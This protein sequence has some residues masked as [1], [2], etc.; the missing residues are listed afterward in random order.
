MYG[1]EAEQW[2]MEIPALVQYLDGHS[3]FSLDQTAWE[4][5]LLEFLRKTLGRSKEG[6][7]SQELSQELGRQMGSY[8][9]ASVEKAFLCK[10]LGTALAMGKD[11]AAVTGQ[12]RELL[13]MADY[14][15]GAETECLGS[16]LQLCARDQLDATLRALGDFE[17]EMAERE[18]SWHL[19]LCKGL[20]PWERDTVKSAL[21]LFY[22]RAAAQAPPQQLLPRL[23]DE[24]VPQILHHYSTSSQALG[25]NAR[26]M[27]TSSEC[28]PSVSPR[29]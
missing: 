5:K 29:A 25:L 18:D 24:I 8:A 21:L 9:S 19:S 11:V 1:D 17:E 20:A 26:Q 13:C 14:L 23:E 10:A 2:W 15:N 22:S 3:K 12:L 6:G 28:D 27:V 16:C 7:W 4:H